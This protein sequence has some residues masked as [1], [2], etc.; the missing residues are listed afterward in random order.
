MFRRWCCKHMFTECGRQL[1][2]EQGAYFGN[3]KDIKA[4]IYVGLGKNFIMHNRLLTIDDYLM[5]GEDV[6]FLGSGHGFDRLDV[7]MG[8]QESK[9]KTPLYIAGDVWIGARVVVL[10][11]CKR[12]GHG[13]IIGAGSV[14]TKDVPDYAIVGGNPAKLIRYRRE[15]GKNEK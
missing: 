6:M 3:G 10:P 2:V 5:M 11:G 14:V 1:N 13:A 15:D 8:Q 4:G 12:I 7:P 9:E